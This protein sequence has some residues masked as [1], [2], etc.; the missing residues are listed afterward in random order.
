MARLAAAERGAVRALQGFVTHLANPAKQQ[1]ASAQC[2]ELGN[3][4]RQLSLCS[5]RLEADASIPDVVIDLLL[6]IEVRHKRLP[7]RDVVKR[8]FQTPCG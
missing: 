7:L 4:I 5:A 8:G 1:S 2:R 6:Q 3:L